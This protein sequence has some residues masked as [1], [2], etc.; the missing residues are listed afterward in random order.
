M[1]IQ[2]FSTSLYAG[3]WLSIP[4]FVQVDGKASLNA[5]EFRR[6]I[7][8]FLLQEFNYPIGKSQIKKSLSFVLS[9]HDNF[10]AHIVGATLNS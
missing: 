3:G 9:I 4:S 10:K 2:V 6:E 7:N 1:E 5:L 8:L